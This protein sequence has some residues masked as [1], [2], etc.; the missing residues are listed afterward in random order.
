MRKIDRVYIHHSESS[1]NTTL[2][3]IRKWHVVDNGWREIGY[4]FLVTKDGEIQGGRPEA[5]IGAHVQGDNAMSL[6][7][8]LIGDF[9]IG[10]PPQAQVDGLVKLLKHLRDQYA[11]TSDMVLGH[12]DG[13]GTKNKKTCPGKFLYDMLPKIRSL[14]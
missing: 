1:P 2:A 10:P 4:H 12:C 6:G 13:P 8:C 3:E 11:V 7:V 14:I 9:D 5:M